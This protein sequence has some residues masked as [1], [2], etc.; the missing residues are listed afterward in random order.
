MKKMM[1]LRPSF[2]LSISFNLI[3]AKGQSRTQLTAELDRI[4]SPEFFAAVRG[5]TRP[6]FNAPPNAPAL[7]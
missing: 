2:L 4:I 5:S 6:T 3:L 7:P 1:S